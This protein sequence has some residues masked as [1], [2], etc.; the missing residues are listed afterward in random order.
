MTEEWEGVL[1]VNLLFKQAPWTLSV[2]Y[3]MEFFGYF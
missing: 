3:L 1:F 2:D